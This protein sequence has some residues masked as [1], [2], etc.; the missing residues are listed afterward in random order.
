[1]RDIRRGLWLMAIGISMLC[2]ATFVHAEEVYDQKEW[3]WGC[4]I[5]GRTLDGGC[6]LRK[7][8]KV[9]ET[10]NDVDTDEER[11]LGFEPGNVPVTRDGKPVF[12]RIKSVL[13]LKPGETKLVSAA[14]CAC[15]R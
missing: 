8:T 7:F 10:E 5:K 3:V 6:V 1:M 13:F 14:K 12:T 9:G 2:A 4:Q 15:G 11:T